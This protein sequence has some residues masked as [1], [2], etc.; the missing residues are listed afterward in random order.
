[1]HAVDEVRL[2]L[3]R[4]VIGLDL[5]PFARAPMEAGRVRITGSRADDLAT[6]GAELM[7]EFEILTEPNPGADTSGPLRGRD[8]ARL[9][10]LRSKKRRGPALDPGDGSPAE[11]AAGPFSYRSV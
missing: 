6:L 9:R 3:E 4:I 5:C 10:W 8:G 11:A 1:M 7:H 2:W